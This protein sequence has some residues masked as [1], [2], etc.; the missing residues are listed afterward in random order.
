VNEAEAATKLRVIAIDGP[1]GSGKSTVAKLVAKHT[2]L[3]YLDTGAMYRAIT[4]G[5]L[6]RGIDPA[7][8][9]AID[10]ALPSIDL[11]LSGTTVVVDGIDATEAIRGTEVT[12]NVS[13][14]SANP[15][16]REALVGLQRQWI[17]QSGAGVLEGRDIGTVV[18]P[19]AALK[20]YV[21]ATVHE[22]AR[23]R[24]L[25]TGLDVDEV[26]AD[27]LRRDKAD[28]EREESPLRA[29]SDAVTVDTTD[30]GITEVVDMIVGFAEERELV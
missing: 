22:R 21:I 26:K 16:V 15:V 19:N 10:R 29:A 9:S 8:W 14:V 1:A 24:S 13:A 6:E 23:R 4:F 20:V 11:D 2:G 3:P 25:E 30:Y 27:L 5:V 7:D 28:S 12:A 18:A 17:E